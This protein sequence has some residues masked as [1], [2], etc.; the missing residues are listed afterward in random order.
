MSNLSK[1]MKEVNLLS[2]IAAYKDLTP[3]LFDS[4]S[5]YYGIKMKPDECS[6]LEMLVKD[7]K[8][9]TKPIHF[10]EAYFIGY[11]IPQIPKE[12][13]LLRIGEESIVNIELKRSSTPDRIKNQLV[14][15]KYYLSFLNKKVYHFTYVVDE[16]KFYTINANE[17][18]I[19]S[20]IKELFEALSTQEVKKINNIDSHFNPSNYLVSPFNSTIEFLAGR[21]F[22]TTQQEDIKRTVLSIL[23]NQQSSILAIRGK[24]GTGKTLLTYDIAK[25][26]IN[27]RKKIRIIHCGRLNNGH[28]LLNEKGWDIV[29]IKFISYPD[30][31]QYDLTIVDEAQRI[32]PYQLIQIFR[33]IKG[34]SGRCIFSYD[35]QQT[36]RKE[37][38]SNNTGALIEQEA[39]YKPFDLSIKIRTN[40]E[41]ASFIYCLFN[42]KKPVEKHTYANVELNYFSSYDEA[43]IFI[44]QQ[45]TNNWKFINYTSSTKPLPYHVHKIDDEY[46]NAHTVMGQEFDNV[47]ALI[48]E[49]FYYNS[50]GDLDVRSY[51]P[52]YQTTSMLFQIVSRTRLKLSIVIVKNKAILERCLAI[53]NPQPK[54]EAPLL[55]TKEI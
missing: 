46:D 35:A 42:T 11:Q 10:Y 2:F 12:F 34:K 4:Y 44:I 40:K 17:D 15:N 43:V 55:L 22:L 29:S 41:I 31:P 16:K 38:A 19:E 1:Q 23:G 14:Q 6:D 26:Y 33:T 24:A 36:L 9:Q 48:D 8:L 27:Q 28:H 53:T 3:E 18:L 25:D 50:N 51:T 30:I 13:D 32:T 52:Y 45:R 39:T 47:I 7:M 20:N 49:Y 54:L 21:Y 5:N 37:E